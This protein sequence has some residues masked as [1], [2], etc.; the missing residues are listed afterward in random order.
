MT[1]ATEMPP[2][3]AAAPAFDGDASVGASPTDT[4]ASAANKAQ[5]WANVV[6]DEIRKMR[7]QSWRV[8]ALVGGLLVGGGLI[9]RH[10]WDDILQSFGK[11]TA[12]VAQVSIADPNVQSKVQELSKQVIKDLLVDQQT[13][14]VAKE[15]SKTV[16][17]CLCVTDCF[18]S[19]PVCVHGLL[20][21]WVA[22]SFLPLLV[23]TALI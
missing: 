12:T 17:M 5:A 21:R 13:R 14:N 22:L 15:F 3:S 9:V 2:P 7:T 19:L 10:L 4:P 1:P 20:I 23:V 6:Y 18:I 11:S 8:L 16:H